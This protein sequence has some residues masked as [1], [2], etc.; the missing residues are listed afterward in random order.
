MKLPIIVVPPTAF[1]N[2]INVS[3]VG[4]DE[5]SFLYNEIGARIEFLSHSRRVR[6]EK[7]KEDL[8]TNILYQQRKS[9]LRILAARIRELVALKK[10][11]VLENTSVS[12][13]GSILI[14][15]LDEIKSI[16]T[17]ID[18]LN[19]DL[20]RNN[21][22]IEEIRLNIVKE[23]PEYNYISEQIDF[24]L[25][26]FL[27]KLCSFNNQKLNTLKISIEGELVIQNAIYDDGYNKIGELRVSP[28]GTSNKKAA[29]RALKE[30]VK[31][32]KKDEKKSTIIVEEKMIGGFSEA[33]GAAS[34]RPAVIADVSG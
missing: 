3:E 13:D 7:I 1:E 14:R 10:L 2:F 32:E 11:L 23:D 22:E 6:E 5:L 21:S 28:D 34:G 18:D 19:V 4:I 26:E 31:K 9:E 15:G 33:S 30:A 20:E 16:D 25:K 17:Q 12:D 27:E 24:F 29:K 8:A